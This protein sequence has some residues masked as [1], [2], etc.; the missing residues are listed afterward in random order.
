MAALTGGALLL[1]FVLCVTGLALS[2]ILRGGYVAL[3]IAWF[4]TLCSI[5]LMLSAVTR[6]IGG[7]N[8]HLDLWTLNGWGALSLH[9]D[10]LSAIFLFATG[11]VY[12]SCCLFAP[13]YLLHY[14]RNRYPAG[15]YAVLHF[16]L[17][18]SVV[19]ILTA[20]DTLTFLV[21]WEC[22]SILCYLLVNYEQRQQA[23][24][25]AGYIMLAMSEAG[26]LAVVIAFLIVGSGASGPSFVA[27]RVAATHLSAPQ[28][29]AYFCLD[30]LASASKQAWSP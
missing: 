27:L 29:G 6:L 4:G 12:L 23:D 21:S 3:L 7:E 10:A 24:S 17:M 5:L 14:F 11:L 22:M 15:R 1:F 13:D 26:F 2:S 8:F 19:L 9:V 30:S 18:A 16:A 28:P 20:G 25:V